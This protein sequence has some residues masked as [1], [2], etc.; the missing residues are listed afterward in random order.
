MRRTM[1][2]GSLVSTLLGSHDSTAC[3][4]CPSP[5]AE[6]TCGGYEAVR[7]ASHAS[8]NTGTKA[9]GTRSEVGRPCDG[10]MKPL[11]PPIW[12]YAGGAR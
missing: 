11:Q 8:I 2:V 9:G 10:G 3:T 4:M 5:P 1:G 6:H 7:V 12:Q